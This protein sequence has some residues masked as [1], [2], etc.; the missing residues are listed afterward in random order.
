MNTPPCPNQRRRSLRW[1][2]VVLSLSETPPAEEVVRAGLLPKLVEFLRQTGAKPNGT[3]ACV[4]FFSETQRIHVKQKCVLLY[5]QYSECVDSLNLRAADCA[6]LRPEA[7]C[8]M[9][10]IASTECTKAVA[11]E[12]E[13]LPALVDLLSSSDLYLR[14]QV[15][16]VVPYLQL[17]VVHRRDHYPV[18]DCQLQFCTILKQSRCCLE[19]NIFT[20]F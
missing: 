3:P 9:T 13:T 8:A 7:L 18:G 20:G 2:R 1:L 16:A 15:G 6:E 12:P 5:C 19:T 4:L 10:N 11:M 14:E 17:S